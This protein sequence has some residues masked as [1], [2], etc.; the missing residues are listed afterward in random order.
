MM[1]KS[2]PN[3]LQIVCEPLKPGCE[4]EY[5]AVEED[6]ARISAE[7]KCPHPHLAMESLSSPRE[8]W[9]L[10][11]F[12]SEAEKQRVYDDYNKNAQLLSALTRNSERKR[13][14]TGTTSDT[15]AKYR[16][17]LSRGA[18][19]NLAG[20]R[21]VVVTVTNEDPSIPGTVFEAPDGR[22][23]I[24]SPVSTRDEA[25]ALARSGGDET[26]VFAVR[27]QWGMPAKEWVDADPEFWRPNPTSSAVK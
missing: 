24:M 22:R 3:I 9:W 16:Q 7:L 26:S 14:L 1:Q 6:T 18:E 4:A 27:P 10:N 2:P 17:D 20:A 25:E 21:F 13:N 12:E 23:F 11:A 19:W 8:V 15:L 5:S